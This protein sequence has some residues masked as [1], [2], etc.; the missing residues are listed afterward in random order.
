[1]ARN[2]LA[3]GGYVGGEPPRK[4][5]FNQLSGVWKLEDAMERQKA[6]TWANPLGIED[7][8]STYLYTGNGS[9]QT[10]TNGIDLSG[11]GG[12]VWT[13]CRSAG[14]NHAVYD[15]ARG[16]TKRLATDTTDA[17]STYAGGVTAFSGTGFSVG[18]N[19]D[20]NF[21]NAT[22]ASWTFRKQAKFFDVVTY[23]GTG[24]SPLTVNHNL[25]SVPGCIIIK[26][27]T[28]GAVNWAV[29]HRSIGATGGLYLNGT[30]STITSIS[31][32][33]NTQPTS[34]SFTVGSGGNTN[35]LSASYVA[36]LFAHDAGGFGDSGN[37]S[38]IKC[39]SYTGNGSTTGPVIDLGWEPQWVM[40][41]NTT[42]SVDDWDIFDN[43]RGVPT[44]GNDQRLRANLSSAED[45][46]V[47]FID[48]NATG[49]Q[50]GT[51]VSDVNANGSTYIYIA[52]RRGPMKA[53][54]DATKVFMADAGTN[55]TSG[56][57][58]TTGFPVD[59]DMTSYR[60][61]GGVANIED[62]VRGY[63]N[64][65]TAGA[66]RGLLTSSTAAETTGSNPYFYNAWNTTITRGSNGANPGGA[67]IISW[68]FRRAPGFFD[69]V[70]YTGTG[71]TR[72]VAHNLGVAPELMI[73]KSRSDAT[74]NWVVYAS[75]ISATSYL[76]LNS[77]ASAST[78]NFWNYT[79]PT[80]SAFSLS[81]ALQ[82]NKSAD[83]YVAY[84]FATCPGVSKVGS[85][86]G[87]GTTL[88][89]DCG[90]TNG[91]RFVLIKRIDSTGDWYVW[92]T[93][94]GIVSGNDP[95]LLL[96]STTAEVTNT[97]YIDPLSSGFQ[98]SSTAPAAINANGGSFIYLAV[99]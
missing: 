24:S 38:V 98:I 93:A 90:F 43:M 26:N 6:G 17:E 21:N 42:G 99:A 7:L 96:N 81:T 69:V 59:M 40:I 89:V 58:V 11:K 79:A 65:N 55:G 54:T 51:T 74:H 80:A 33:N 49:F 60:S 52:I 23:T 48:F 34:T 41:K 68:F 50:P 82:V 64:T 47:N 36:Y 37:E 61:L 29:Y 87:T 78:T 14:F 8:F 4:P 30:D 94:R 57:I 72:T 31:F 22:F 62:R 56:G 3:P 2:T 35:A 75:G 32:W 19:S 9:T 91:A 71:I 5:Y 83:N 70:A 27:T 45:S 66:T 13:K 85:Y 12:L 97:D 86:T 15:T 73:V 28:N 46:G 84:L 16:T 39:G 10:I 25:G 53:P 44:G 88:S 63:G 92:D 95:S 67:G 18:N 20:V 76:Y 77:I 1:M